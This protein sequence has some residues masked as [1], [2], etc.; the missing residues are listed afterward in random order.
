MGLT[1]TQVGIEEGFGR[2]LAKNYR[3][4]RDVYERKSHK[5]E[6]GTIQCFG[7]EHDIN[8]I[9]KGELS[10]SQVS[11]TTI[12]AEELK[13]PGHTMPDLAWPKACF[14]QTTSLPRQ[15]YRPGHHSL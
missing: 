9:H 1:R 6:Y 3:V 15:A 2:R 8:T 13:T 11:I 7:D 12:S 4:V 14:R 5:R 10:L